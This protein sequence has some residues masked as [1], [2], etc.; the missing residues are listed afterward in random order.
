MM[1]T[2]CTPSRRQ[3]ERGIALL[4]AIMVMLLMSALMIGFTTIVMSDQRFRG[5]DKDKTR[6][7]YG[8]QS[9]LEKLTA[10]LGNLFLTNVAPTPAQIAALSS[11]AP[12]IPFVTFV[13]PD[14]VT[15]YGATQLQFL[16]N[17]VLSGSCASTV[18]SGPYQGLQ[19][20][21]QNYKLDVVAKTTNGGEAHLTRFLETV[22]I[23]VFQFGTFSDVDL[24]FFAGPNFNFG[25]RVH[26][27]GNLFLAEGDGNTLTLTDK[28]TAVGQ[29]VRQQLANGVSINTSTTHAG[30]ISMAKAS[31]S[32]RTLAATEGSVTGGVNPPTLNT[33]WPTISLS[34][35]NGYIRNGLTGAKP[36]NLPVITAGGANTDLVRRPVANENTVNPTLYGE[37]MYGKMSLRIL[38]SDTAADITT[39]PTVTATAPIRLGDENAGLTNDWLTTPPAGYGPVDATHPPIARSPGLQTITTTAGTLSGATT[40]A[41]GGANPGGV[42]NVPGTL[43][44]SSMQFQI[45]TGS[46]LSDLQRVNCL[47]ATATGTSA[48]P[49]ITFGSCLRADASGGLLAVPSGATFIVTDLNGKTQN[50][51]TNAAVS[52]TSNNTTTRNYVVTSTAANDAMVTN[53]FW[54][55]SIDNN[56]WSLVTCLGLT[57][58]S[59]TANAGPFGVTSLSTCSGVPHTNAGAGV[60]TTAGLVAQDTGT[61]GG[62]IKIEMQDTANNW[63]DVTAEILN[64]G[65]ADKNQAGAACAD[66]TPNAIIRLQRLRDSSNP[67]W[68]TYASSTNSYDYWPNTLFDT[69]E[70][71]NRDVNPGNVDLPLAGVMHYIAIDVANLSK[72]LTGQA[73]YAAGSGANAYSNNGYGIYISDRRNNRD[74]NSLETGEYGFEDFV[75]PSSAAGTRNGALDTGE[76]VNANAILDVYGQYPSFL[77]VQN[78]LPTG[79]VAPFNTA[80]N[81]RPWATAG[82]GAMM[83]NRAYLFRRAV[84]LVNGGLGNIV[85]PGLT[86]ATENP[87]YIQGDWNA[88]QAG[89]GEPNAETSVI[90]DAVTLL[91][92]EWTDVNSFINPYSPGARGRNTTW[93]RVAVIAGKGAAFPWP[94]AGSP[95]SDFGT[96]GG[97][98]NFLRLLENGGTVNYLGATATFYYNRQA[99]GVYKCCSTVYGAPTRNYNFDTDFLNPATLPPFT[100]VFRDV[101]ITGYSQETR[102]GK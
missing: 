51:V 29:I 19:A 1:I 101:N 45:Q 14:G 23:P 88:N 100:P 2:S 9:G 41:I 31:N 10:D 7:Y 91:S 80:T 93:Y 99:T 25:G 11:N 34:T 66:P 98:H 26:T 70:A 4:A 44:A 43:G 86:I 48:S 83:S 72:W 74:A 79:G 94:S 12:S 84:K 56:S 90:A 97:A 92:N 96:D 59:N 81:V 8:A 15:A 24:S 16:C 87:V 61:I 76:D 37:R 36:L 28:V 63:Q 33:S 47:T 69:R 52:S 67:T 58:T 42:Y 5:I 62:Y 53:S 39:L 71:L 95:P 102:P 35:Y 46:P 78:T 60:I 27:N 57:T 6:A 40:I 73:P 18:S 13:A 85:Q 20:I 38:L 75:N 77:G 64:W 68:C 50:F 17:G 49:T 82:R 30:T 22:A 32:F 21:K 65:F 3:S 54:M 89:F 55:Q